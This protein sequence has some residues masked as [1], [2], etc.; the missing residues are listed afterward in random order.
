MKDGERTQRTIQQTGG[1]RLYYRQ[2]K[3]GLDT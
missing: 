1:K 3:R 2:P